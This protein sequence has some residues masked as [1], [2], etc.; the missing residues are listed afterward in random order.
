MSYSIAFSIIFIASLGCLYGLYA[1]LRYRVKFPGWK[2]LV[3]TGLL[4]SAINA[5]L[6]IADYRFKHREP[7]YFN[8]G[9]EQL[10]SNSLVRAHMDGFSS[11]L[12]IENFPKKPGAQAVFQIRLV[13]GNSTLYLTCT[14]DKI[15]EDRK[16]TKVRQDSIRKNP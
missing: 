11:Y 1:L 8:Q 13:G 15:K 14:M 16:L 3:V 5:W 4:M 2:K 7:A 6:I 10:R 9:V 12:F